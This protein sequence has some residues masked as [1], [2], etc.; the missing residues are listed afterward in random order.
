MKKAKK[1]KQKTRKGYEYRRELK[2]FDL[3][4]K[5]IFSRAIGK[6]IS[7]ATGE[8][9]QEN[10][11]DITTEVKLLKSLRPDLIFRDG[12]KIFHIEIQA[13]QDKTL[14]KRMLIYSIYLPLLCLGPN[15]KLSNLKLLILRE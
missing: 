5:K 11:E 9:I 12:E 10:L 13:Q 14:P 3:V 6:I 4:L 1:Q 8:K 15:S 2:R 7:I